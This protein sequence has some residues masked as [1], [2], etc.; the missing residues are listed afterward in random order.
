MQQLDIY[1]QKPQPG[2]AILISGAWGV[3]KSHKWSR[4]ASNLSNRTPVTISAAGL[5]KSED[6]ERALLQA[7]INLKIPGAVAE[8][9]SVLGKALLRVAK[10]E[11]K[12]ITWKADLARDRTV[13]CIDD[14]ERFAG[15]FNVIFGFIVNLID[16]SG[17]YCVLIADEVRAGERFPDYGK[18]KERIVSK[19]IYLKPNLREFCENEIQGF[20]TPRVRQVLLEGLAQLLV[21]I[22]QA[23][24]SN[25]RSVRLFLT[26]LDSLAQRL[27]ENALG[28]L[29][30]SALPSAVLFWVVALARDAS[31]RQLAERVF[32]SDQIGIALAMHDVAKQKGQ[33]ANNEI[34]KL[35]D[36][37]A[38]LELTQAVRNWPS[39]QAFIN[40]MHG[41]DGVDYRDLAA[42]FGLL[43][44]E[45]S[46]DPLEV[47]NRYASSS[48]E[49][50]QVAISQARAE[51]HGDKAP[52]L[53]R[54]FNLYRSLYFLSTKG[55]FIELPDDW[56]KEVLGRLDEL[57]A[58]PQTVDGDDY[59]IWPS[60]YDA[61][62]KHVIDKCDELAGAIGQCAETTGREEALSIL[63]SGEGAIPET[64]SKPLFIS[65]PSP[66]EF[67]GKLRAGG[68]K[69]VIRLNQVFRKRLMISNS[70]DLVGADRDYAVALADYIE[71]N[72]PVARPMP[73]VD[74]EL[75]AAILPMRQFVQQVD[76]ALRRR[77]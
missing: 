67:V 35:A 12:D 72:V 11:P 69:A 71:K 75:R 6:L 28:G 8:M 14:I 43:P 76:E 9:S 31:S 10:I 25:L 37:L 53:S 33:E 74:A 38:Q 20:T 34:S 2:Y 42:Q 29:C 22:E 64:S 49:E 27:P 63:L 19:S 32:S 41:L 48:D 15:P 51:L 40:H 23:K 54:V 73:L 4:Y 77:A 7:S 62:E 45:H 60:S 46:Y 47:I 56:T 58:I 3:G 68:T 17:V 16:S 18:Y 5:E 1:L 59:E 65:A 24:V 26:E 52:K 66:E 30:A 50:I 44:A 55:V 70:P 21:L 61:N 57:L 39:S 36:L 13:V